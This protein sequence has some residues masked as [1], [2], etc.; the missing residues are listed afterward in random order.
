MNVLIKIYSI[1]RYDMTNKEFEQRVNLANAALNTI[2]FPSQETISKLSVE[3]AKT[4]IEHSNLPEREK[5][6][7]KSWQDMGYE[8]FITHNYDKAR[9]IYGRISQLLPH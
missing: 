6:I 8:L 2:Y 5:E 9:T 3:A 1:N 7:L 4:N